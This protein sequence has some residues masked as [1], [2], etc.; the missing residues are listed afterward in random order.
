MADELRDEITNFRYTNELFRFSPRHTESPKHATFY[1]S[2]T[3]YL[4]IYI[5]RLKNQPTY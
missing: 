5:A 3:N 4:S 1:S 2:T